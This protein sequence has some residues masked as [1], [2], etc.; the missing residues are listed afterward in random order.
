[1]SVRGI[2]RGGHLR[3]ERDRAREAEPPLLS[4]QRSEVGGLVAPVVAAIQTSAKQLTVNT[5]LKVSASFT[6][7]GVLDTHTARWTWG[8]G[9]S[10]SGEL[11]E[12][13]GAGTAK[14]NHVYKKV[15]TYTITL[16]I[17]DDDGGSNQRF[18]VIVVT[19]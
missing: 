18:V 4:Q 19:R 13:N 16:R 17:T 7:P 9:K 5:Q 10:N 1:M 15:G 3:D 6:D 2:E 11:T 12:V 8:D 14:G